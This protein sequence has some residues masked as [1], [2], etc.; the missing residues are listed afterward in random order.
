MGEI[1]YR[2]LEDR[3]VDYDIIEVQEKPSSPIPFSLKDIPA[4]NSQI[5]TEVEGLKE[6]VEFAIN[7]AYQNYIS[8]FPNKTSLNI[9]MRRLIPKAL[10]FEHANFYDTRNYGKLPSIGVYVKAPIFPQNKPTIKKGIHVKIGYHHF[11]KTNDP[12]EAGVFDLGTI[13]LPRL[14]LIHEI[15]HAL[16]HHL[17]DKKLIQYEYKDYDAVMKEGIAITS[18]RSVG[19]RG[20]DDNTPHK[21]ALE[22]ILQLE[23]LDL[24]KNNTLAQKLKFLF[25]FD[26]HS[27]LSTF[28]GGINHQ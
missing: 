21:T 15:G 10:F 16:N 28:L 20:Y 1:R 14:A 4:P 27:K 5:A 7:H 13:V 8:L 9:F 25:Q 6:I 24:F 17:S 2:K 22:L 3:V 23:E 18:A 11:V 26:K 19:K 12:E